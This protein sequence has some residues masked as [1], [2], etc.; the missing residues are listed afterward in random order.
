MDS[1]SLIPL[2]Q[3]LRKNMDVMCKDE[4]LQCSYLPCKF[5]KLFRICETKKHYFQVQD[6]RNLVMRQY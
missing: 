2:V 1:V 3:T 4:S 6:A 5:T